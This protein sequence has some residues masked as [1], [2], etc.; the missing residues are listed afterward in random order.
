MQSVL[1]FAAEFVFVSGIAL[2]S[3]LFIAGLADRPARSAAPEKSD[4]LSLFSEPIAP[5]TPKAID[6]VVPF[7]R[8]QPKA[9]AIP[10]GIAP[11]IDWSALDPFQLRKECAQRGIR[12]RNSHGL[13]KHLKKSEMLAALKDFEAAIAS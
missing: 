10:E 7:V 1:T 5:T 4:R 13:N 11:R 3:F 9:V 2:Y 8:P 12:W 6:T